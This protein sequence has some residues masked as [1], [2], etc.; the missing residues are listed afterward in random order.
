MLETG[1]SS[2]LVKKCCLLN[3]PIVEINPLPVINHKNYYLFK[4]KA[5]NIVPLLIN[6]FL[7]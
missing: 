6:Q 4:D 5:E 1:L 3:I 7:I 2:F